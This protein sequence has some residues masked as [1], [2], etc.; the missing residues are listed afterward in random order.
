M[1]TFKHFTNTWKYL[2]LLLLFIF[3]GNKLYSQ[4]CQGHTLTM[5]GWGV[6]NSSNPHN[7]YLTANFNNA[8][9]NGLTLGCDTGFKLQLSSSNAVT[10]FLPSGGTPLPLNANYQNPT[11]YKNT[12]AGQ[13]V[14]VILATTF[15]AYDENFSSANAD[16]GDFVFTSG[17]FQGLTVNQFLDLAN[18]FMGGCGST[19][20]NASDFNVAA[21]AI[22]ENFDE[23][24]RDNGYLS[25]C[26]LKIQVSYD[27]I[28]CHGATTVVHVSATGGS[29]NVQGIGDFTVS[30]GTHA[31]TVTDGNCSSTTT[32][33]LT[34]PSK[35]LATI[36]SIPILCAGGSSTLTVNATG[37]TGNYS[38]LWSTGET[39]QSIQV[40]SG[41]YT[42]TVTD[43]NLCVTS[44]SIQVSQP[45]PLNL[46]IDKGDVICIGGTTTAS[47]NVSGGTPPYTYLWSNG[48]TTQSVDLPIG[49]YTVIVTDANGCVISKAFE[50]KQLTCNGFTTITQ[51]GWGAKA[52]G[53]NWG[54]YR[55]LNFAN[56]FPDG[57]IIGSGSRTIKLTTAKAV[58]DFLPSSTTPRVLNSGNLIN[59]GG[60]YKNVLAGQA[61]ALTL[62]LRFDQ[63]NP[64]FSSSDTWLGN[65]VVISG[66][67]TGW[68][69]NQVLMEANK[70]L[71]GETS[72]FSASEINN[73]L[74]SINNNY[75]NGNTNLG[76]LAC[77]CDSSPTPFARNIE[78]NNTNKVQATV[79]NNS[80][81]YPNPSKGDINVIIESDDNSQMQALLYNYNGKMVA[82]LSKNV[83][84]IRNLIKI[85]YQNYS[86][87]EGM[88]I[89]RV[90]SSKQ[91]QSFKLMIKR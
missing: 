2:F 82:D 80:K 85:S 53:N 36:N 71:G 16:L 84:R 13:L 72:I 56:A 17:P 37:G 23:G 10:N 34:E 58:D 61:V 63:V 55:D 9:P 49:N 70:I 54:T 50:V 78:T 62:N 46:T 67:F 65:L 52:A 14:S 7:M 69:V 24:N 21:T 22:N 87:P 42:V 39:S 41:S 29:S 47:A 31:F 5:G 90:Q 30:A 38:Y 57:L 75:D 68:T 27:S 51:G 6:A 77:P 73:I 60:T 86:L 43:Q 11:T 91:E 66:T 8:F 4:N 28:L 64:N 19:L 33:V 89:L 59:P 88:Y 25:C 15:D 45:T 83:S 40:P 76:L 74:D 1:E 79:V 3:T 44:A 81:L 20:Y 32:I 26:T 18:K 12:L 48:A 35:L